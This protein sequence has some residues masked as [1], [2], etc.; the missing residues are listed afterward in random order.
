MSAPSSLG[1]HGRK[2]SEPRGPRLCQ[3]PNERN[4]IR[5]PLAKAGPLPSR[6][7]AI[8]L[9]GPLRLQG[10]PHKATVEVQAPAPLCSHASLLSR[11]QGSEPHPGSLY[12]GPPLLRAHGSRR[13]GLESLVP[14]ESSLRPAQQ[15]DPVGSRDLS[16]YTLPWSP[17][18]HRC[19]VT[20]SCPAVGGRGCAVPSAHCQHGRSS[21]SH[22]MTTGPGKSHIKE[23]LGLHCLQGPF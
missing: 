11:I 21:H 17:P 16:V 8:S 18:L 13:L 22:L 14:R 6:L 2:R 10:S 1:A 15:K 4:D 9:A 5:R 12:P 3:P 19:D 23:G 20:S 7:R